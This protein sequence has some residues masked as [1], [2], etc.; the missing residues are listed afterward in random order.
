[1]KNWDK[2][3]KIWNILW[4]GIACFDFVIISFFGSRIKTKILNSVLFTFTHVQLRSSK[5]KKWKKRSL[6]SEIYSIPKILK[7]SF[8]SCPKLL[9]YYKKQSQNKQ[10]NDEKNNNVLVTTWTPFFSW[11]VHTFYLAIVLIKS[12]EE[13]K[14]LIFSQHP[15][16]SCSN[17]HH[18]NDFC[19]LFQ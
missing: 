6:L 4:Y 10:N 1:M 3:L 11:I 19:Q 5:K 8:K 14:R 15:I 13:P 2:F 9:L 17:L 18:T 12:S 16:Y 7:K